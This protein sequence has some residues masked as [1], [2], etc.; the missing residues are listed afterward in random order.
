MPESPGLE[1]QKRQNAKGELMFTEGTEEQRASIA[2]HRQRIQKANEGRNQPYREFDNL[3]FI[4][5]YYSNKDAANSYLRPKKN[6]D[7]VR[8]VGGT[9]EK[10]LE[11]VKNELSSMNFQ[12]EISAWDTLDMIVPELGDSMAAA[13]K[14]TKQI[15]EDEDTMDEALWEF[16]T[17]RAVYVEEVYEETEFR[18]RVTATYRKRVRANIE[19][20]LGD[21]T[22]PA[23]RF[24]E[25]P[26]VCVY[27]RMSLPAA[28]RIWGSRPNFQYVR[29]G[30]DISQDVYGVETPFRIGFLA[31]SE[32]E[33]IKYMSVPDD[34][35]QVYINGVPMFDPGTK[36]PWRYGAYNLAM[37]IPKRVGKHF[38]MGRSLPSA[39]KYL[40]ALD[41]ETVRNFVRK[42]RQAIEPP[43]AVASNNRVY[44]RDIYNAGNISYG[45]DASVFKK[46][47]DHDGVT[48][49]EMAVYE[50]VKR[51]QD[52]LA[53]RGNTQLGVSE[54]PKQTATAIIQQQQNAVKML[55]DLVINWSRFVREVDKLRLMN[56]LEHAVEPIGKRID[57][58]TKDLAD[59]YQR[60]ALRD[61]NL[62]NG[63]T[64]EKVVQFADRDLTPEE[65][66]ALDGFEKEQ[67]AAGK[68]VRVA[69][70]NAKTLRDNPFMW[71]VTV[72]SKP[73]ENDDLHRLMFQDKLTQAQAVAQAAGRQLNG[74]RITD[75]FERV[76]RV[77]D[78][79]QDLAEA[80]P[81]AM[82]Q[83]PGGAAP[84]S[85]LA[86]AAT[87]GIGA[88]TRRQAMP[89]PTLKAA[90]GAVEGARP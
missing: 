82:G 16:C 22:I 80:P 49:G 11:S 59:E 41:D 43:T 25:Q 3:T 63:K 34:E 90:V 64:G 33:V 57:P 45:V 38:A 60:F 31:E 6:D 79:F 20:L 78:W 35:Y 24:Q 89:N 81:S 51:L 36:L 10:R 54:G 74:G 30:Q 84:G 73:K 68:P 71:K 27:D 72:V 37:A 50:V 42:M 8:V 26:Y 12:S 76:W 21:M 19:V 23:H 1:N 14:R 15:E 85:E 65:I 13:V 66:E 39:M 77:H 58:A 52:E 53:A 9:T 4:A 28:R 47:T 55:G 29:G 40:Q 46:L 2:F 83:P 32:V 87:A 70:I 7:E 5:D 67:E 88:G 61:E 56:L 69:W 75:E 62:P 44:S 18:G 17:Q 48:Q 86:E